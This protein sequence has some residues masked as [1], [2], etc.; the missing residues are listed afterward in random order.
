MKDA[1]EFLDSGATA[2]DLDWVRNIAVDVLPD[3]PDEDQAN[4]PADPLPSIPSTVYEL[5][6]DTLATP[7][8]FMEEGHERDVFLTCA[9]PIV[10]GTLVNVS[11]VHGDGPDGLSLYT[12]VVAEAGS[13][14]GAARFARRLGELIDRRL[15]EDSDTE[16]TRW[17]TRKAAGESP[18][19]LGP[20]PLHR[21]FYLSANSSAR[22]FVDSL[23]AND[24]R[25]VLYDS[26]I[27]TLTTAQAQDWGN[28][29]DVMLKA[30][31][32]ESVTLDRK[33]EKIRI[34][35][36]S[37][38]I[39]LT[40]TPSA[41]RALIPAAENGLLSRFCLYMFTAPSVWRTQR[42][43]PQRSE[44]DD[45][46]RTSGE[47]LNELHRRLMART[48]PLRVEMTSR[49]WD[50]LDQHFGAELARLHASGAARLLEAS[51][52]RAGVVAFRIAC[53]LA[54]LEASERGGSIETAETIQTSDTDVSAGLLLATVYLTHG[55]AYADTLP[56]VESL[57]IGQARMPTNKAQWLA[58]L[59]ESFT[60]GEAVAEGARR[61]IAE[62]TVRR[63]LPDLVKADVIEQTAYGRFRR[64]YGGS[65]GILCSPGILDTLPPTD[66]PGTLPT[67]PRMPTVPTVPQCQQ[68]PEADAEKEGSDDDT[69]G[70]PLRSDWIE[71]EI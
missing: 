8:R 21:A 6:P 52:K 41:L 24:G 71:G 34:A 23:Y 47:R 16:R 17:K 45:S 54:V 63:R 10:A 4:E 15:Y 49:Q 11:G 65:P 18:E 9:L 69:F 27:L 55:L 30:W 62:R 70:S 39:S 5:L 51:V 60:T 56:K 7:S 2:E 13:G 31:Q 44:R 20:E 37:L 3:G 33:G 22:A 12:A 66:H 48:L 36:P 40:G 53:T 1:A 28:T 61:E 25:G 46:I 14:K 43:S 38:S 35:S 64:L 29:A 50:S 68:G 59:P 32:G 67:L 26:E 58:A 42:P 57:M 19:D